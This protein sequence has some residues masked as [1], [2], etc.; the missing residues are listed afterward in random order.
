MIKSL[1]YTNVLTMDQY[2]PGIRAVLEGVSAIAAIQQV[3]AP[4]VTGS[5]VAP[6]MS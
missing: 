3:E 5:E 2:L 4:E 1:V 6:A